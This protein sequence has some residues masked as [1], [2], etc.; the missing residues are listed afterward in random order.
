MDDT[1]Q[2]HE[3]AVEIM[4]LSMPKKPSDVGAKAA[5]PQSERKTVVTFAPAVGGAGDDASG[6]SSSPRRGG[7]VVAATAAVGEHGGRPPVA[8]AV[9]EHGGRPPVAAAVPAVQ[10]PPRTYHG[11]S[12][13][14]STAPRSPPRNLPPVRDSSRKG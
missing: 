9:G 10:S 1:T 8:A 11:A 3:Y 13:S 5:Q 4:E 7:V 12:A 6:D 2:A 14:A